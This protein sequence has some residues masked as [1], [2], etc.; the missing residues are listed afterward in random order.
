MTKYL[1]NFLN[2]N[3]AVLFLFLCVI[4]SVFFILTLSSC[5]STTDF[6]S[7][8]GIN[9]DQLTNILQSQATDI[10]RQTREEFNNL[11]RTISDLKAK[12]V[13]LE[14]SLKNVNQLN[15]KFETKLDT[16][17]TNQ[18]NKFEELT[19]SLKTIKES[20]DKLND[21]NVHMNTNLANI[22]SKTE[23]LP[24][25]VEDIKSIVKLYDN[26]KNRGIIGEYQLKSI[27]ENIFGTGGEIVKE[28]YMLPEQSSDGKKLIIDF[29]LNLSQS[30]LIDA[31][32]PKDN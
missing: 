30:V 31:K 25:A 12:N 10:I 2:K 4:I 11:N 8:V 32:F 26:S 18:F 27:L 15:A 20:A 6:G 24:G 7:Q 14:Q 19:T 21:Y 17:Y 1:L 23:K 22:H 5:S 13:E 9:K 28:Q 3:K 29:Y 16:S